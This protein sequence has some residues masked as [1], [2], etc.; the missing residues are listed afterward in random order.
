MFKLLIFFVLEIF[1]FVDPVALFEAVDDEG[2]GAHG[3]Q[4]AD[5]Q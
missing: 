4:P 2:K 1:L 5:E 3:K